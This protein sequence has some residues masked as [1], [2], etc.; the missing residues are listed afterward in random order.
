MGHKP[1]EGSNPSLSAKGLG[2]WTERCAD[3]REGL[4]GVVEDELCI[5]PQHAVTELRERPIAA[6]V[7]CTAT[8]VI[9]AVHFHDEPR[10]R[11]DEV[12][13]IATADDHLPVEPSAGLAGFDEAPKRRFARGERAAML[14]GK[15][16][17]PG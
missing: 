8:R 13:D 12:G 5:E 14:R 9:L 15:E 2:W 16:L 17:K 6:S 4:F 10:P 7:R 11:S 1:I 3:E